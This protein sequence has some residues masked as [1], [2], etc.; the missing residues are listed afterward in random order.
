[1]KRETVYSGDRWSK[2]TDLHGD[3]FGVPALRSESAYIGRHHRDR[4]HEDTRP[5]LR[6]STHVSSHEPAGSGVIAG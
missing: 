1:M 6:G 4:Q 3:T 2:K 5:S